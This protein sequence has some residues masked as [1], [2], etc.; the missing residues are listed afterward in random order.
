MSNP[1]LPPALLALDPGIRESGWACFQGGRMQATG[2]I[3][4]PRHLKLTAGERIDHLTD[5]LDRLAA[6][7]ALGALVC[8]QPSGIRWKAPSLELL[9]SRL[10]LWSQRH[11]LERHTYT[12]QEVRAAITGSARVSRDQLAYTITASLGLIGKRKTTHEWEAV[13]VGYYH[14]Y[15]GIDLGKGSCT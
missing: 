2:C 9:E 11:R 1:Q 4:R 3:A 6:E 15:R 13:A 14:L 8:C 5:C 12:A 10:A 7:W